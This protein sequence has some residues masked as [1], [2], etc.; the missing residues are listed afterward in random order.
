MRGRDLYGLTAELLATGA[1]AMADPGYEPTGV[2]APVEAVPVER[3][4]QELVRNGVSIEVFG[5]DQ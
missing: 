3:W 2:L 1:I 4:R 5:T